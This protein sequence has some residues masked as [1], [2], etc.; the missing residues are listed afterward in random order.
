MKIISALTVQRNVTSNSTNAFATKTNTVAYSIE[1]TGAASPQRAIS[2]FALLLTTIATVVSFFWMSDFP[3]N[4]CQAY[5]GIF[6]VSRLYSL[7]RDS[8]WDSSTAGVTSQL[9]FKTTGFSTRA[10]AVFPS[11]LRW[12]SVSVTRFVTHSQTCYWSSS[13]YISYPLRRSWL[14]KWALHPNDV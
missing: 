11:H 1:F 10:R 5:L 14:Y 6:S 7:N 12:L 13:I 3:L 9:V 8:I 4:K 2:H